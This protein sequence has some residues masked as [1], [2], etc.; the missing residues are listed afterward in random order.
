[1]AIFIGYHGTD[2]T[3]AEAILEEKTFLPSGTWQDWLGRGVYFF[4]FDPH[5]AFMITKARKRCS[6]DKIV[7]LKSQILSEN[8]LD[9]LT[10]DDRTFMGS[11]K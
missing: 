5:Q 3:S 8:F 10:D 11:V 2:R 7:V 1:M 4:E 9:L 6:K